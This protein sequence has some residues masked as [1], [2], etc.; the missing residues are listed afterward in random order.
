MSEPKTELDRLLALRVRQFAVALIVV[1]ALV[2]VT[3][4]VGCTG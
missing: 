4:A 2:A 3:V 1:V